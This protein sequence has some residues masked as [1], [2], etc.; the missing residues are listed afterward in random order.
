MRCPFQAHMNF[1]SRCLSCCCQS[2]C[3]ESSWKS[4]P[5]GIHGTL[6][7]DRLLGHSFR[8]FCSNRSLL[9]E[10]FLPLALLRATALLAAAVIA[11]LTPLFLLRLRRSSFV[12]SRAATAAGA[13]ASEAVSM[14]VRL[15]PSQVIFLCGVTPCMCM[16]IT[17]Q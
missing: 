10:R 8:S 9:S 16:Y 12:S 4:R 13:A 1:R 6:L 3:L 5:D 2:R 15:T 7:S 14:Q 11:P 17:P